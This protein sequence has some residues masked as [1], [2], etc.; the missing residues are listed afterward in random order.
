[1]VRVA[2]CSKTIGLLHEIS[3]IKNPKLLSLI[4]SKHNV[5]KDD[6][7]M[8]TLY[9]LTVV[10]NTKPDVLSQS[11][12]DPSVFKQDIVEERKEFLKQGQ[13]DS[14]LH[15]CHLFD[16]FTK[17]IAPAHK[18]ISQW[19]FRN[20]F[21]QHT[22]P[23]IKKADVHAHSEYRE[24]LMEIFF[25]D[26]QKNNRVT[27]D[28]YAL[29]LKYLYQIVDRPDFFTKE[30]FMILFHAQFR[31][32]NS[33]LS[34]HEKTHLNFLARRARLE[35]YQIFAMNNPDFFRKPDGLFE[36]ILSDLESQYIRS[37]ESNAE[38]LLG[39]IERSDLDF[40]VND[41]LK[42]HFEDINLR[43]NILLYDR[44]N[45]FPL[46]SKILNAGYL[47]V[48]FRYD[49]M[50]LLNNTW[51]LP[52][53]SQETL[54]SKHFI[55]EF[56]G[57]YLSENQ[58]ITRYFLFWENGF[59]HGRPMASQVRKGIDHF[60]AEYLTKLNRHQLLS[61]LSFVFTY[62]EYLFFEGESRES[63]R[64]L[65]YFLNKIL[66][67]QAVLDVLSY[68]KQKRLSFAKVVDEVLGR[69]VKFNT[70]VSLSDRLSKI[71]KAAFLEDAEFLDSKEL[72]M[73]QEQKFKE[74]LKDYSFEEKVAMFNKVKESSDDRFSD[75]DYSPGHPASLGDIHDY[76]KPGFRSDQPTYIY[77]PMIEEKHRI[78]KMTVI[79]WAWVKRQSKSKNEKIR[80]P[81]NQFLKEF[82]E[83]IL[84]D[85][86]KLNVSSFL[87][88]KT[89]IFHKEVKSQEY[90]MVIE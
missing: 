64:Q 18:G 34:S 3:F 51:E 59:N 52:E 29:Y 31:T 20:L 90:K 85:G 7:L 35:V 24:S 71:F 74:K 44:E 23:L 79:L 8:D 33:S 48:Q 76:V 21:K 67:D 6:R 77:Y 5:L 32:G 87:N 53:I 13:R 28:Q 19:I 58:N 88:A 42:I 56:Y 50:R 4:V 1:M 16:G 68:E 37:S 49:F 75:R 45:G 39:G 2:F 57:K 66:N 84:K 89:Q 83:R 22:L 14:L 38:M 86:V 78:S 61:Q 54:N 15:S 46:V 47:P 65:L 36:R 63:Q 72:P 62:Y 60:V 25:E 17:P 40:F 70:Q 10:T 41:F 43:K 81:F 82:P 12:L 80:E 73:A 9:F 27:F 26:L 69:L 11:I 55:K 30:K